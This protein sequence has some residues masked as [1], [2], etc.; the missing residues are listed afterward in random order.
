MQTSVLVSTLFAS[1]LGFSPMM[2]AGGA[3]VVSSARPAVVAAA[4]IRMDIERT[5]ITK[6]YHE[7]R[8]VEKKIHIVRVEQRKKKQASRH[9]SLMKRVH[10]VIRNRGSMLVWRALRRFFVEKNAA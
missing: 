6:I 9:K 8:T 5:Y 4:N 2:P 10:R 1:A 3:R 7:L